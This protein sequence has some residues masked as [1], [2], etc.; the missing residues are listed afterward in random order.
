MQ[1]TIAVSSFEI[2]LAVVSAFVLPVVYVVFFSDELLHLLE[3]ID[4]GHRIFAHLRPPRRAF[5][6]ELEGDCGFV[7]TTFSI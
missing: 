2:L 7:L 3:W 1:M 6:E 5:Q 4:L